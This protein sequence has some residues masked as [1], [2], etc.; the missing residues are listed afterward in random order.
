LGRNGIGKS[1]LIKTFI[2]GTTLQ[3]GI[4]EINPKVKIG[5]FAQNTVDGISMTDSPLSLFTREH[6]NKREQELRSYLGSYGFF[7]DKVHE[8][9]K[10]FSGGVKARLTIANII[11]HRPN[12]I[13]LDEP[14][15][16]LDMQMREELA[17]SIQDFNGAVVIVSHD[18][19]LLQSVVDEFYLIDGGH[20][21][22]FNGDLE[23]YHQ[24]LLSKESAV[25]AKNKAANAPKVEAKPSA[26]KNVLRL[27][28]DLANLEQRMTKLEEQVKIFEEQMAELA[29]KPEN[30]QLKEITIKY[31]QA[32]QKLDELEGKWLEIH[33]AIEQ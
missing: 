6:P 8:S 13:F 26:G 7:G 18:K 33:H 25:A 12:I 30:A 16:H 20:L 9:I 28:S 22:P 17:S 21:K 19:F 3:S 14:T 15:N 23:E 31:D 10:N 32:K 11:L 27:K 5:Y 1:T 2:D 29:T 24:F 4:R